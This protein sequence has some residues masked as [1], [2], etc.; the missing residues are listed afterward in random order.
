[1]IHLNAVVKEYDVERRRLSTSEE[2]ILI[3]YAQNG[4]KKA[5]N[6]LVKHNMLFCIK[7]AN[8]YTSKLE[9]RD[10]YQAAAI[11]LIKAIRS[12]DTSRGLRLISYAVWWIKA[13]V[14]KEIN[15]TSDIVRLPNQYHVKMSKI[16]SNKSKDQDY[17]DWYW[18]VRDTLSLDKKISDTSDTTFSN[19]TSFADHNDFEKEMIDIDFCEKQIEMMTKCMSNREAETVKSLYSESDKYRSVQDVATAQGCSRARIQD[20]KLK[21]FNKVRKH[22]PTRA[23]LEHAC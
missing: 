22:F 12:A 8:Q 16:N 18:S 3:E 7:V 19:F 6:L 1:M 20:I 10:L 14:T 21:A 11:G 17:E 4:N 23:D 15:E 13:C 5:L 9:Q 2:K